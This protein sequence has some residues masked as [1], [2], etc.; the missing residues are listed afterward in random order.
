MWQSAASTSPQLPRSA[1]TKLVAEPVRAADVGQRD[2]VAGCHQAEQPELDGRRP[3]PGR[4]A[5][6]R[7]HGGARR[8]SRAGWRQQPGGDAVDLE[9][10][11]L[12]RAERAAHPVA[13]VPRQP[14][15]PRGPARARTRRRRRCARPHRRDARCRPRR[16]ARRRP[17]WPACGRRPARR[18]RARGGARCA[19][20]PRLDARTRRGRRPPPHRRTGARPATGRRRRGAGTSWARHT[21][22]SPATVHPSTGPGERR[23]RLRLVA[24]PGRR[25]GAAAAAPRSA[26]GPRVGEERDPAVGQEAGRARANHG[27]DVSRRGRPPQRH[28]VHVDGPPQQAVGVV[29]APVEAVD[30]RAPSARPWRRSPTF[31]CDVS[32]CAQTASQRP[33]GLHASAV[34]PRLKRQAARLATADRHQPDLVGTRLAVRQEGRPTRRRVRSARVWSRCRPDVSGRGRP[35]LHGTVHSR[36]TFGA[37]GPSCGGRRRRARRRPTGRPRRSAPRGRRSGGHPP[38]EPLDRAGLP[39]DA[40]VGPSR[41][42]YSCADSG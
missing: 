42:E 27:P 3:V 18:S 28:A 36:R 17:T 26:S 29:V 5:V 30:R 40:P 23:H 12:R 16:S 20:H 37:A 9:L 4:A 7:E 31:R 6:D 10:L 8:R 32:S 13:A 22:S 35:P 33:S 38:A 1:S 34:A 21:T 2:A 25:R 39:V 14:P 19:P 41:A 15:R 24:R 11:H